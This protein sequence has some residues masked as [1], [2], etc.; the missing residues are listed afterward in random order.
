[1][2]SSCSSYKYRYWLAYTLVGVFA[3]MPTCRVLTSFAV[4][5]RPCKM[6]PGVD[7]LL[8]EVFFV[9]TLFDSGI[10]VLA[11]YFSSSKCETG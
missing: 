4:N 3:R 11:G 7:S 5:V 2:I 1:M 8:V 9:H 10:F 6:P